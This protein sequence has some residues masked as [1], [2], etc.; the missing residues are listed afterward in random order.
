MS[1]SAL[2]KNLMC[3]RTRSGIEFW[4]EKENARLFQDILK[5]LTQSTFLEIEG[6]S[7]N[8]ADLEGVFSAGRIEILT[9]HKNGQWKCKFGI[10]HERSERCDCVEVTPER[11]F[12]LDNEDRFRAAWAAC[13]LKCGN[14]YYDGSKVC[15]CTV[16]LFEEMHEYV[17]SQ[18]EK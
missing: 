8:T 9:R 4:M 11:R 10:W 16:G 18:E 12:F 6:E 13:S 5:G 17:S 3:V 7:V 14:G 1:S 2:S 15:P